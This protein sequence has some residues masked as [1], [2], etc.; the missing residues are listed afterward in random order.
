MQTCLTLSVDKD[1]I[2][3]IVF[4]LPG[5]PMNVLTPEFQSELAQAVETVAA[6]AAVKGAILTS[7]KAGSFIAGADIRQLAESFDQGISAKEG[8]ALSGHLSKIFRRLETC[9]KPF[10]C[11]INGVAL[12]GGFEIALACHY[13]VLAEDASVGQPEVNLGLLPGGGG[14]Q[15]VPRLIG[16]EPSLQFLLLGKH[17]PAREALKLG[18]VHAV[19]KSTE[20]VEKARQW[21][22]TSPNATQPWDDKG[23]RIPGGAGALAHHA[24]R[25]FIAGTAIVAQ[26][27][28]RNYP[29]PLAILSCIYE[30][31]QRQM[32][33]GLRIESKY[34]GQLLSGV[35]ARNLMRTLFI[36]KGT[37]DKLVRRPEGVA[38]S[39]VQKLGILGAGMMGAGIA[40]VSAAA[41]IDVVLLDSTIEQAEK[42]KQ[43]S[44]KLLQKNLDRGKTT[45]EKVAAQ[46][47]RIKPTTDYADLAACD[48]VIEA[49][50]ENR[51]VKKGVTAKAAAAMPETAIFASNTS[52]LP[53]TGLAEAY[54]KPQDFIGLHFFS[55][56]DKM[57]LVEVIVGRKTSQVTLARALDYVAQIK[58]TPI[59]V[60]DSPG[61]YV[62]RLFVAFFQEGVLMLEE[63]VA[64]A[65]I[66]N[67]GR[68]A[69]MP[70]G[71]LAVSDEI[72]LELQLKVIEQNITDGNMASPDLPRVFA[73]LE[74]MV[75]ELHRIGRR[76]GAGYY[77]YA[78]DK[79]APL[80]DGRMKGLWPGL[81][82][83]FPVKAAQ[84][85]V[86]EVKTRL[87][88]IQ[89][90][91]AA[92]CL[93]AGVVEHP[94]DADI[95]SILGIGFPAWTGG[96]LSFIETVGMAAFVKEC[97]RLADRYGERFRPSAW[98]RQRAEKSE[99]FYPMPASA[100]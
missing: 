75:N 44:V 81:A 57:P 16:I 64:P 63:G 97:D 39:K 73:V 6:D 26:T 94:A 99:L 61:F 18:L 21:L 8:A 92:R 38:K 22:L 34:F 88:Y 28:Q 56:V 29:A 98:L 3:L 51:A 89:A 46:L 91:E 59:V 82:K 40:H 48:L 47:A 11:A 60:N 87:L 4:D 32:D 25:S 1:G 77:D 69:G 15:R 86:E 95:G 78:A 45:P 36:N 58:K 49:V 19:A 10:A 31:T 96:A 70:V 35:V 85:E 55:P 50:F 62:N 80:A 23:Y 68:M 52:T 42:G 33:V 43:Y 9:G 12:G 93:E 13:R 2:A 7:G 76:G 65:L 20:V 27:T 67:A 74:M 79:A 24:P 30:G 84:P 5:R 66:E 17:L 53:I 14:T 71:P 100:A 72:T 41:G 90:L 37:A 83:H 54:P